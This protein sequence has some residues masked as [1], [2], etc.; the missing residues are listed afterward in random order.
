MKVIFEHKEKGTITFYKD[1]FIT[2]CLKKSLDLL[3]KV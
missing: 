1:S 2:L 3:I